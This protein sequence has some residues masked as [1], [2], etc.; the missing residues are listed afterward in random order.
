MKYGLLLALL[1]KARKISQE[2]LAAK[3]TSQSALSRFEAGGEVYAQNLISYL[4]KL[5]IHPTEFFM[6]AEDTDFISQQDFN[7]RLQAA[8]V[9]KSDRDLLVNEERLRYS[10]TGNILN[11]INAVR[12]EAVY[13]KVHNLSLDSYQSDLEEVKK[14]LLSIDIWMMFE[15][16]LY[17]DL[18]FIFDDSFI[19]NYHHRMSRTLQSLPFGKELRQALSS[20]YGNNLIVL[21]FERNNLQALRKHIDYLESTLSKNPRNLI[22]SIQVD[23]YNKMY[24]MKIHYSDELTVEAL[25]ILSILKKYR[26]IEPYIGLRDLLFECF[27]VPPHIKNRY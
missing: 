5:N 19:D 11:L 3:V 4:K 7:L 22:T 10:E 13:A 25:E 1:R 27:I 17:L 12:V 8:F 21:D 18:L 26:Y 15:V 23:F 9:T 14:Y 6:L 20:A 16:T 24:N 2:D